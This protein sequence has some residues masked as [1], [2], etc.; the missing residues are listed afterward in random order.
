M[1]I[2]KTL[3]MTLTVLLV[4]S[5]QAAF[6]NPPTTQP[7]AA[8]KTF[9]YA[10]DV[11][12][13]QGRPVPDV[14]VIATHRDPGGESYGYIAT[15]RTDAKG[16]FSIDRA[17]ALSGAEP[18]W[19]IG[20]IIRLEFL[21]KNYTYARLEDLSV[22]GKP[23]VTDLHIKL[24]EGRSVRGR[25]VDPGNKPVPNASV[26]IT[27][28]KQYELRRAVVS[29]AN[30]RFEING[31]PLLKGELAVLTTEPSQPMMSAARQITSEMA[32]AGD[33]ILASIDLPRDSVIH[34]LFGMKLVDV[35]ASVQ[36][37]FHLPRAEGVLV[38]DPGQQSE[39]L[40]IGKL[41]RGDQFWIVG[42]QTVKNFEEF[43]KGLS[44]GERVVYQF[45]RPDMAGSNTQY[46]K[47]KDADLAE[48]AK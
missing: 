28:G 20:D 23:Q 40:D 17:V 22:L 7:D 41:E 27:F 15:E 45:R 47:L 38:I 11:V 24:Q 37:S 48:L 30:G 2:L 14:Q 19:V 42:E 39:R 4:H 18:A 31:L 6:G 12:D 13:P 33:V 36:K 8:I 21:H 44:D 25:V 10:G 9:R 3:A 29:D 32:E 26:E 43:K 16:R 1:S 35:D 5:R 46:I 34:Q